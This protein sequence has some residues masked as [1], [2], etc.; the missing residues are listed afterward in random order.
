LKFKLYCSVA[1]NYRTISTLKRGRNVTNQVPQFKTLRQK[2]KHFT[3]TKM[4]NMPSLAVL[5]DIYILYHMFRPLLA[6]TR[7]I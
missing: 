2:K 7:Y 4:I 3:R 5:V 1:Q 6:I